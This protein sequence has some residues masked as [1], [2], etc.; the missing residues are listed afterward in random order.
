MAYDSLKN[1][2]KNF[3]RGLTETP[4]A[5]QIKNTA[6]NLWE[7]RDIVVRNYLADQYLKQHKENTVNDT[8]NGAANGTAAFDVNSS[9]ASVVPFINAYRDALGRQRDL[10]QQ[11]IEN[12][13]R[14]QYQNIM[15]SA[16]T[17]GMMYSNFPERAKMLYDTNTYMPT[18]VENQTTYQTGL[19][20]LRS[21]TVNYLNQLKEIND[22][23][24]DLSTSS[25]SGNNGDADYLQ[26]LYKQLS[27][28]YGT[29]NAE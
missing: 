14:N 13:R 28:L 4:V 9:Y 2:L 8:A 7:N 19:D 1:S 25:T 10:N 16:N 24:A 18:L 5:N 6:N 23:I 3:A 17:L 20:K 22:A 21:N 26:N 27:K 11:A 29:D 15:G 12:N